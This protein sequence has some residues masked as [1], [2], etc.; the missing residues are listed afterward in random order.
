MLEL[1][2]ITK[3][4]GG[5]PVLGGASLYCAPGEIICLVGANAAGKTTLLSIAAGLQKA[6]GGQVLCQG[7]LGFVPQDCALLE[8][9]TVTDNLRLWY[10]AAGLDTSLLFASGT[11]EAL[12]ELSP[13]AGKRVSRLSGGIKKRTAIACALVC[14]PVCLL[15]DEPFTALDQ[16]S[17]QAIVSLLKRLKQDGKSVLFS[18]HD[19]AA[20]ADA[21]DKVAL[22]RE[23][24]IATVVPLERQEGSPVAQVISLLA[25]V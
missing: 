14:A 6:D 19:P 3:A 23:G 10:A 5:S 1:R 18:S 17:R 11:T 20:I 12:L 2:K 9:L 25:Q 24:A 22:L 4:F 21:A 13:Y 7:R 8:E 15:M 16:T